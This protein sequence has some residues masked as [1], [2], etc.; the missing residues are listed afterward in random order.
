MRQALASVLL[1]VLV[2]VVYSNSFKSGFVLDNR[3]LIL[4]D[5]RVH[6]ASID[7]LS[8]IVNHSYW[9]PV[10]ES[11]LYRP[12]TTLSYLFNYAILGNADR[13]AGYHVLNLLLHIGNVLLVLALG[14]R[15]SRNLWLAALIAAVWAVHPLATEA[16]TNIVGRADLL[17]AMATLA[18]LHAHLAAREAGHGQRVLW[19][20]V[21]ALAVTVGVFSKENAVAVIAV[22]MLYDIVVL[23][24]RISTVSL[25]SGWIPFALPLTLMWYQRGA[26]LGSV[27]VTAF[28]FVDN[29]IIGAG[30]WQGRL[31]AVVVAARYL[32][33]I[34]WPARLS[35]DYS[36]SQIPLASGSAWEW[37][38]WLAAAS[39]VALTVVLW[40][41]HR[42]VALVVIAA[43][44]LFLPVS[45][46]AFTTGT[47]MAER[48]MYLPSIGLIAALVIGV[49]AAAKRITLPM[50]A[51]IVLA[52][53]VVAFGIRT[54]NRNRDWTSEV[55]LWT[56]AVSAAP[57]SFK[58]HGALAEALYNADPTR[59]NLPMVVAAKERSLAILAT[60]PDPASVPL[61]HREAAAYYLELGDWLVAQGQ[62]V[63][64]PEVG[65]AYHHAV[66]AANRFLVLADQAKG[67][68]ARDITAAQLIVSSA[69]QRLNE[70]EGAIAAGRNA[71]SLQPFNPKAYQVAAAAF[72]S[73]GR[74]DDAAVALMSGF[75]VTGDRDLRSLLVQM[76]RGGLDTKHCAVSSTPRGDVLNPACEL[77]ASHLCAAGRD[78]MAIHRQ[79]G[80]PD[81]AD[82][83]QAT[84][85]QGL[86][87]APDQSMRI[88][89]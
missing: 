34:V 77:V 30:F 60:V 11:G 14:L 17:A 64:A 84:T 13:P 52:L 69:H 31:T 87:C 37:L 4:E 47:I 46:L 86:T 59:S 32:W 65:A 20:L 3:V 45:N 16:V 66:D 22:A 27:T 88:S 7:N 68:S 53:L 6:E 70:N 76:Y 75:I 21:V 82:Q 25:V 51:P 57:H 35:A 36:F 19:M 12:V 79:N 41:R 24:G 18:A 43:V 55:S 26:V 10:F 28:P 1:C 61:P 56:A 5:A 39:M 74:P 63:T 33:L 15:L 67:V 40:R 44:V 58:T 89:R 81:L 54:W 29:P 42:P 80:H 71:V 49:F 23:E 83:I 9:W 8:N 73:A 48:L 62:P 78:A 72:V 85:L 38:A 50:A 2:L